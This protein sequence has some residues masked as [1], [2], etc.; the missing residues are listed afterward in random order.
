MKSFKVSRVLMGLLVVLG[1]SLVMAACE[2]GTYEYEDTSY[3]GMTVT[4]KAELS[5]GNKYKLT[6]SA[7]GAGIPAAVL[8]AATITDE[9]TYTKS[10]NDLTFKSDKG[11]GNSKAKLS[12]DGKTLTV[13]GYSLKKK[14]ADGGE[15]YFLSDGDVIE[16]EWVD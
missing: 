10:G 7:S 2:F 8:A 4:V 9:G 13:S 6:V 16:V 11:Y 15:E 3:P 5:S 14:S 1:L 12:S